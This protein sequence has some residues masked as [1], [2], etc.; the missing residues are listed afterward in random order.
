[1]LNQIYTKESNSFG[2]LPKY[3][4]IKCGQVCSVLKRVATMSG[5]M[6]KVQRCRWIVLNN[7]KETGED[8]TD[9]L[10]TS[11][12]DKSK[13]QQLITTNLSLTKKSKWF[14]L[15]WTVWYYET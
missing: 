7:G 14:Q 9:R 15:R 12:G 1:M 10:S 6:M 8:D 2:L 3:T 13:L 4:E 11:L 5:A